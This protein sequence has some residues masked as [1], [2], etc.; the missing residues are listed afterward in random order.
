GL[1]GAG[2]ISE[3]HARAVRRIPDA[4]LIGVADVMAP[5]ATALASQFGI[6]NV[7]ASMDEMIRAG[8][9]VVHI[10]T[11]PAAHAPLAISALENGCH[12]LIEKPMATSVEEVD[13]I[14]VA[15]AA[16]G[17]SVCVN[18][19]LLYDRFV[20]KALRIVRSG[21]IGTPLSFDYFRSS[22]YPPY[23][24]GPLPVHYRDGGYPFLDHGVHALYLAESFLGAIQDVH[25]T[26]GTHGGDPNLLYDEWRVSA[27]CQPGTANIQTFWNVRT[28]Q[29]WFV[30]Q[31]TDGVLRA[32]LFSM[33]VKHTRRLPLPK[34][35]ARPLQA[36]A[37]GASICAQVPA[38]VAR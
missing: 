21:A 4:Q 36:M 1:V 17:K 8:V 9:D 38:N 5:R 27:Q 34:A 37:E 31:G 7:Y 35:A 24:G 11:P 25:A 6:P 13:R 15:A 22:D 12:V 14:S 32:N 3:F 28:L 33:W 23:R 29:N 19:S 18:H 26:Y 30:V 10:L 20:S 16:A 2:Y